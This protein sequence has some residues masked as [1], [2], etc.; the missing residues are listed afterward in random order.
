MERR[1][2]AVG[3][4]GWREPPGNQARER[5]TSKAAARRSR[6]T[7]AEGSAACLGSPPARA[8]ALNRAHVV[9]SRYA[10]HDFNWV[11]DGGLAL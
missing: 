1:Q 10:Q 8:P 11:H 7:T 2:E 6:R 5:G 3:C 9:R 4:G